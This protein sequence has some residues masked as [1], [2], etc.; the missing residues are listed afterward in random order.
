MKGR[1]ITT[2]EFERI[3]TKVEDVVGTECEESWKFLLKGL[4][5][6]G[7]RLG[8]ALQLSWE[9]TAELAVDFSGKRPMFR[10]AATT[11]IKGH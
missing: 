2:E 6:S 3:L 5:S 9:E 11:G 10:I 8:E 4:W 7:L 1:P